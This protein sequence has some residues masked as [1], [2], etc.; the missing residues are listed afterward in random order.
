MSLGTL[1]TAAEIQGC[2]HLCAIQ[3]IQDVIHSWNGVRLTVCD[4]V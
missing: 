1:V 4:R 2:E 3:G